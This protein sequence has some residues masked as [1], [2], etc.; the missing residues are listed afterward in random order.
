MTTTPK[1]YREFE[2]SVHTDLKDSL[3]GLPPEMHDVAPKGFLGRSHTQQHADLGLPDDV[4]NRSDNHILIALS[5]RGEDLSG[6]LV[7]GRESFNRFQQLRYEVYA[8]NDFPR[9]SGNAIASDPPSLVG[10][11]PTC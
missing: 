1:N 4:S 2:E 3:V 7:M 8:E 5:R 9:L 11:H 10:I 6:N